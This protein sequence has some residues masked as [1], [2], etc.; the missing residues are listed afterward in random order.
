[1]KTDEL[2]LLGLLACTYWYIRFVRGV[3]TNGQD[4]SGS[5]LSG[6]RKQSC[7]DGTTSSTSRLAPRGHLVRTTTRLG[8]CREDPGRGSGVHATRT[9]DA[10]WTLDRTS[11]RR[12]HMTSSFITPVG[13]R[14]T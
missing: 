9:S 12:S 1:M 13:R 11:F 10:Q 5:Q 2:A 6:T 3:H 8:V 4:G 7:S 14:C